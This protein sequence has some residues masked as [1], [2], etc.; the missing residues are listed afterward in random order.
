M[1]IGKRRIISDGEMSNRKSSTIDH[2]VLNE[3]K[4]QSWLK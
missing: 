4:R 2:F 1:N 3:Q